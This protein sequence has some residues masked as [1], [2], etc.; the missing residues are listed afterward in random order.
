MFLKANDLSFF[1]SF[2]SYSY[3]QEIPS[4]FKKDLVKA[5][6]KG[7]NTPDIVAMDGLHRLLFNIGATQRVS[8]TDVEAIFNELGDG[9]GNLHA[10][11]MIQII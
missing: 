2:S 5:A 10:Q 1:F 6:T 7:T 3:T 8:T 4:R 9:N 11:T